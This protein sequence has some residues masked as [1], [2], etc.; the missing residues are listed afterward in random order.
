MKIIIGDRFRKDP[1]DLTSLMESIKKLGLLHPIV[2]TESGMLVAGYRRLMAWRNLGLKEEDIPYTTIPEYLKDAE[3]EENTVRKDFTVTEIANIWIHY[4]PQITQEAKRRQEELGKAHGND[5]FRKFSGRGDT[6]DVIGSIAGVS[7]R[8]AEKAVKIVETAE[9]YPEICGPIL[10]KVE[11]GSISI[12]KGFKTVKIKEKQQE[13]KETGSPSLPDGV[14]DVLYADPPWK[15][16]YGG[17][18][19]GVA[20]NHYPTMSF[21]D[22]LLLPIEEKAAD[23]AVL[24]LWST[25]AFL[26]D[27]LKLGNEWGFAY[28]T[29]MVWIKQKIGTGFWVRNQHELLLIFQKGNFP[30]PADEDRVSSIIK[31]NSTIHSKKPELVYDLIEKMHPNRTYLELFARNSREK[32]VSWGNEV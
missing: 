18:I 27:A 14:Y 19:R 12:H 9:K 5:P 20:E 28:K 21:N 23:N 6:R 26:E 30:Y 8:T 25:N 10:E 4:Q 2:L 29:C 22:L 15:Y 13:I 1:G 7:G 24:Y 32:W 17:S 31:E 16:D 11:N 3:V